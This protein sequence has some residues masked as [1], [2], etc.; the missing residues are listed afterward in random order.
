ME[1]CPKLSIVPRGFSQFSTRFCF[2]CC[3]F[4]MIF[5]LFKIYFYFVLQWL[6]VG[7]FIQSLR[8]LIATGIRV[9]VFVFR[10]C[11]FFPTVKYLISSLWI[12]VRIPE[13]LVRILFAQINMKCHIF[14]LETITRL[15]FII[16]RVEKQLN[17]Q[18]RFWLCPLQREGMKMNNGRRVQYWTVAYDSYSKKPK[19]K[20]IYNF[21]E[22]MLC[23]QTIVQVFIILI[24]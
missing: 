18:F 13:H 2:M 12:K 21:S 20:P 1:I 6:L 23:M 17:Y 5:W 15:S 19:K 3:Y 8:V 22:S 24:H 10:K 4:L 14:L 7:T 11:F 9:S 16:L